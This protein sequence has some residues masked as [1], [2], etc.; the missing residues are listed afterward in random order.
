MEDDRDQ[1]SKQSPLQWILSNQIAAG[2]IVM[3]GGSLILAAIY[4]IP[5]IW[6]EKPEPVLP[7]QPRSMLPEVPLGDILLFSLVELPPEG[8]LVV[9]RPVLGHDLKISVGGLGVVAGRVVVSR[10]AVSKISNNEELVAGRDIPIF[11]RSTYSTRTDLNCNFRLEVMT[12]SELFSK[13]QF[14][15]SLESWDIDAGKPACPVRFG[16]RAG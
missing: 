14:I 12:S 8:A 6:R 4:A 2:I 9:E 16:N 1:G 11:G 5:D 13:D 15:I 7:E 10:L 3:V